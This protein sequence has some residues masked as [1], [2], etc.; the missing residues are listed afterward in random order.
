MA[1]A[2]QELDAQTHAANQ[3]Q[4]VAR[5]KTLEGKLAKVRKRLDNVNDA[6]AEHGKSTSL[7]KQLDELE[8]D[9][10]SLLAKLA[11][12]AEAVKPFARYSLDDLALYADLALQLL[13]NGTLDEKRA[14]IR[15]TIYAIKVE[16]VDKRLQATIFYYSPAFRPEGIQP[17]S[18]DPPRI[19]VSTLTRPPGAHAI[20]T[21]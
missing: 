8:A 16:N 11:E 4:A 19:T 3:A 13:S 14:V 9:E 18:P 21:F 2:R 1:A 20:H 5:R 10:L 15:G 7:F 12:T 17:S 6:I